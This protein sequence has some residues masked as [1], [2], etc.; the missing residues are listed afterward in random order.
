MNKEFLELLKQAKPIVET[1]G[2][3][4]YKQNWGGLRATITDSH[5]GSAELHGLDLIDF[6][7]D[8]PIKESKPIF[9]QLIYHKMIKH[10]IGHFIYYM[11]HNRIYNKAKKLLELMEMIPVYKFQHLGYVTREPDK[12]WTTTWVRT[13][14]PK[15]KV[16][17]E[18]L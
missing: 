6:K 11:P 8:F 9:A 16:M 14:T 12:G 7:E 15:E 5:C 1:P 17:I 18:A 4:W 10:D 2:W 3:E 13:F